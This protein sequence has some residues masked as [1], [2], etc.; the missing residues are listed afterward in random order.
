MLTVLQRAG[1]A[2]VSQRG[3]HL[4]LRGIRNGRTRTVI[5]KHPAAQIPAGTFKAIL[6]QA[7]LTPDEFATLLA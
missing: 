6:R 3:S 7:D 2:Q 1:L 4:K 5:V